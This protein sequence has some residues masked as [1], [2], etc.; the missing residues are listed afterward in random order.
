ME[1]KKTKIADCN[2]LANVL[3]GIC[4][5]SMAPILLGFA[6]GA[7]SIGCLP[8]M[9]CAVPFLI[10]SVILLLVT[11][12]IVSGMANAVLTGLALFNNIGHALR[13]L[14]CMVNGYEIPGD[15]T[16]GIYKMDGIAYLAA[17]VFLISIIFISSK[18]NKVQAVFVAFPCIGFVLLFCMETLGMNVGILPG[19]CLL[20]FACWLLYSGIA[21][22]LHQATG[23][24]ILRYIVAPKNN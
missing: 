16:A 12:D 17:A 20:T 1:E 10:I 3:T 19:I 18:V 24:Q 23:V 5:F 7:A 15:V 21:M 9:L 6:P 11:G 13:N 2:G 4:I 22:M 14:Y 8:W